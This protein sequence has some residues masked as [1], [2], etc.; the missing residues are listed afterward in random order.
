MGKN[1]FEA[2]PTLQLNKGLKDLFEEVYVERVAT[3]KKRD[4]LKVYIS[5]DRLIQKEDVYEVENAIKKQFFSREN[6]VVKLYEKFNLSSQY[7]PERLMDIYRDSILLE[8]KEYERMTYMLM[9]Q[10]KISY[11]GPNEI[12]L[13]VEDSVIY[14]S[15]STEL[16]GILDKIFHERCGIPV[17]FQMTYEES[18][19]GLHKEEDEQRIRQMVQEIVNRTNIHVEKHVEEYDPETKQNQSVAKAP[20]AAPQKLESEKAGAAARKE[21]PKKQENKRFEKKEEYQK[22]RFIKKSDNP[23][24]IFGRG[25]RWAKL[26]SEAKLRISING[27]FVMSVRLSALI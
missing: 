1:F 10:A 13:T 6:L 26:L 16:L 22:R 9:K 12:N 15:K 4:F 21:E 8:L 27:R 23:D 19:A 7:N 14:R 3:N 2:F 25:V 17:N 18:K 11:P 5:C 24:V 20:E